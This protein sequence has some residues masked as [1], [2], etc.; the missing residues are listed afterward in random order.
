MEAAKGA[1]GNVQAVTGGPR[2]CVEDGAG[3]DLVQ[4][5]KGRGNTG[6]TGK[7]LAKWRLRGASCM[8][9]AIG[10]GGHCLACAG[11]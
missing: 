4:V 7:R 1:G 11:R 10:R 5:Q 2:R 3:V 6:R 9:N 8:Q